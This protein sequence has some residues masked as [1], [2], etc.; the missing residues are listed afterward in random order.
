MLGQ[1]IKNK[2]NQ[3]FRDNQI[4]SN[5]KQ[6]RHSEINYYFNM[7]GQTIKNKQNQIFRSA[8]PSKHGSRNNQ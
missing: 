2:Q 5:N 3:M 8:K 7:L 6:N 4:N 1:T